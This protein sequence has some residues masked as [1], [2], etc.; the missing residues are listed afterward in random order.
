MHLRHRGQTTL[1][2]FP[3]KALFAVRHAL[4]HQYHQHHIDISS[5]V[6]SSSSSSTL[7]NIML[8]GC[9]SELNWT[10]ARRQ[11]FCGRAVVGSEGGCRV[12]MEWELG[13]AW[14]WKVALKVSVAVDGVHKELRV[15]LY[16]LWPFF[17]ISFR[18]LMQWI[19][20]VSVIGDDRASHDIEGT[21]KHVR[22]ILHHT[23]GICRDL[24]R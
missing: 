22:G 19:W 10:C 23:S 5:T 3:R 18:W 20:Y 9:E 2:V 21:R 15:K 1:S 6:A 24:Q 7:G 11:G 8:R 12:G 13:L 4:G 16:A 14:E 17:S